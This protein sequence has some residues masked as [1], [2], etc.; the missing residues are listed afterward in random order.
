MRKIKVLLTTLILLLIFPFVVNAAT[1]LKSSTQTPIVGSVI[2]LEVDIDYGHEE[3]I[4][5]AHYAISYDTDKFHLEEVIWTQSKGTYHLESGKIFL[6]KEDNG[7]PWEYGGQAILKLKVLSSGQ[8]KI[9]ITDNGYAYYDDGSVV[10]QSFSGVTINAVAPSTDFIIGSLYVEGYDI[11]P[12]FSKGTY[13]YNLS[14]PSNV[15]SVNVV[16]KKGSSTQTI[17]GDGQRNLNYGDNRVRVVVTAENGTTSTYEIMINRKDDRTGDTGLLNLS[18]SNTNIKYEEDTTIYYATVSRSV[19]S[20]LISARA[21]DSAATLSGTGTKPLEIGRNVFDINVESSNNNTKKYTIVITRSDQELQPNVESTKLSSL[22]INNKPIELSDEKSTYL[23]GVTEESK[24]LNFDYETESTTATVTIEGGT[25]L[26]EG[27][28]VVIITVT[29]TNNETRTYRILVNKDQANAKV[30]GDLED[31]TS[32]KENIIYK[33]DKTEKHVITTKQIKNIKENKS[34]V[35]YHVV[36]DFNGLIYGLTIPNEIMDTIYDFDAEFEQSSEA[37]LTYTT[38]LP[39]DVEVKL[40]VGDI[41]P[42]NLNVKLYTYDE[43][44]RYTLLTAGLT[45]IDGYITFNTNGQKNYVITT[46]QLIKNKVSLLKWL[47]QNFLIILFVL[48]AIGL[49][50]Y[51]IYIK[52]IKKQQPVS[53]EPY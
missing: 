38:N 52:V 9:S 20:V 50:A 13:Q 18:V 3:L 12:T 28:N 23:M 17:T 49:I 22:L 5:E 41:Y 44:G 26:Q 10:S 2:Y 35:H 39:K 34:I 7:Q 36:N 43:I 37:P 25:K 15:S 8:N 46:A 27:I 45:V 24:I 6:D 48:I 1:S 51:V 47:Q 42:D 53:N 19:D 14:V 29:E 30:V 32:N 40:Y 4:K 11:T 33:A 21:K 16:A 31:Y